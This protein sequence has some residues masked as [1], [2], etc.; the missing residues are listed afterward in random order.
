MLKDLDKS[1]IARP[2]VK[3]RYAPY[4]KLLRD[5]LGEWLLAKSEQ[6]VQVLR[7]ASS[8]LQTAI[9]GQ[10]LA[11]TASYAFNDNG[12]NTS[13]PLASSVLSMLYY[14]KVLSPVSFLAFST[15]FS[16]TT[17]EGLNVMPV[18]LHW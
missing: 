3:G 5:W 9:V 1:G 15:K 16:C 13:T 10:V 7:Q 17:Q 2:R 6:K 14:C 12:R 4:A 18:I 11:T 8:T